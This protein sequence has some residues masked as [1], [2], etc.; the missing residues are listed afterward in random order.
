VTPWR[1]IDS[2]IALASTRRMQMLTP[3]RAASVQGKHHP[4]QWNIGSVQR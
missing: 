1:L 3:A 4:L 2:M